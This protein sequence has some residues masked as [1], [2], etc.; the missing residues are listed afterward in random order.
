MAINL[1]ELNSVKKYF[2]IKRGPLRLT[3]GYV[4]AADQVDLVIKKGENLGLVGE[5]GSGKTT[6]AK[7]IL[8]LL[9]V[10]S[11]SIVFQ[12][13]DITHLSDKKMVEVRKNMQIVFQDPFGSLDPRFNVEGIISEGMDTHIQR[14]KSIARER[15]E[16][17]LDLVGLSSEMIDRFPH[18]FSGGERQRIAIARSLATNPKFLVLDEAVSSLDVLVQTQILHLLLDL[19]QR[20]D[21]TYLFISHNLRVI[22]KICQ[23]IAVMY[24][25]KIVEVVSSK[26]ILENALHPYTQELLSA[27]IDFQARVKNNNDFFAE[28]IRGCC[29]NKVC[30]HREDICLE[31]E[32]KLGE[33]GSG[34]FVNCHFLNRKKE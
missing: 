24:R 19:Q 1:L 23:R 21:L 10:D 33:M 12:G 22:K 8:K 4:K 34:H 13:Q 32:P 16:G 7:L 28:D 11:G 27:A 6:L 9:K 2:P 17:L 15:V 5:S 26:D 3:A 18:E 31:R 29:Y 20:L 25:G 30:K 14:N